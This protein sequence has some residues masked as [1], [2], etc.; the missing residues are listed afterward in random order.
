MDRVWRTFHAA[1][2]AYFVVVDRLHTD[3]VTHLLKMLSQAGLPV[4]GV[5]ELVDQFLVVKEGDVVVGAGVIEPHGADGLLR[6]IVVHP[7]Y[8]GKG[9]GQM[10]VKSLI[11]QTNRDLYL[12]TETAEHF[13]V[14]FGFELV[15]R[16]EAPAELRDSEEFRC[17][18]PE[19]ASFMKRT[20]HPRNS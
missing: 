6:S 5:T 3:D 16:E 12:L 10:L 8:Q 20:V 15:S 2:R 14:R 9:V 13:F 7:K 19:S 18:C 1:D 11:A 4:S 17:L